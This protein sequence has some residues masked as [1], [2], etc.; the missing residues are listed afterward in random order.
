MHSKCCIYRENINLVDIVIRQ[1]RMA[2]LCHNIGMADKVSAVTL[3]TAITTHNH[4]S[5]QQ[6]IGIGYCVVGCMGE[7]CM[8]WQCHGT[9]YVHVL[10]TAYKQYSHTHTKLVMLQMYCVR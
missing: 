7:Y 5:W 9:Q 4:S 1:I 10:R 2:M 8:Q 3:S 6:Y